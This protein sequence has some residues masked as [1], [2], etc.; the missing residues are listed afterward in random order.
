[1]NLDDNIAFRNITVLSKPD[2]SVTEI[3]FLDTEYK[4]VENITAGKKII[5]NATVLNTG[6]SCAEKVDVWFYCMNLTTN[7]TIGIQTIDRIDTLSW[8]TVSISWVPDVIGEFNITVSV[9]RNYT[10]GEISFANNN[11]T[12]CVNI[13]EPLIFINLTPLTTYTYMPGVAIFLEGKVRYGTPESPGAGVENIE[14]SIALIDSYGNVVREVKLT[15]TDGGYF[16]TSA[17]ELVLPDKPGSYT[18][19]VST[20]YALP[21]TVS[22]VIKKAPAVELPIL[23]II[24]VIIV[25]GC[26]IGGAAIYFR[27]FRVERYVE[28]GE[29]GELLPEGLRKCPKC[30][31]MF[32]I[33]TARCSNCQAWVPITVK[34]CPECGVAF[35]A[36]ALKRAIEDYEKQLK[37]GYQK[38]VNAQ[39]AIARKKLG[40][41]YSDKEFW[42]WWRKQP[43]YLA[44]EDWVAKEREKKKL[45]EIKCPTCGTPHPPR[46]KICTKCGVVMEVAPP[47]PPAVK[48]TAPKVEAPPP[49]VEKEEI[50][51]VKAEKPCI[52]C[53]EKI[54]VD[55]KFCSKCGAFQGVVPKRVVKKPVTAKVVYKKVVKVPKKEEKEGGEK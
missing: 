18:I 17:Q 7:Y 37:A 36:K 21:T 4:P 30:S 35:V 23:G 39:K 34:E 49:P 32:E 14:V 22:I 16:S 26:A 20:K 52:K 10:I 54:P 5:I 27:K 46:T 42:T 19:K 9:N 31:T 25:V 11:H 12:V 29:C 33:S 50:P 15:T 41:K 6:A 13:S 1:V 28:C 51:P 53:G 2:L 8:K 45:V 44:Y 38:Y 55:T 43:T 47:A 48:P 24:A 3:Y 40:P